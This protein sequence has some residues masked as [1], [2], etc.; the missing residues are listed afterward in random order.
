[1][2]AEATVARAA[3]IATT[4]PIAVGVLGTRSI[5]GVCCSFCW[6]YRVVW[7]SGRQRGRVRQR[8][9]EKRVR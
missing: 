7:F 1:M 8:E 9:A 2:S 6:L 3:S 4:M 5:L